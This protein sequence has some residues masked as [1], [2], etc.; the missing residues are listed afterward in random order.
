M[1]AIEILTGYRAGKIPPLEA[2]E[3]LRALGLQLSA[4][5]ILYEYLIELAT[6]N[7]N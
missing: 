7:L 3:K 4:N 2:S 1:T 6:K 5:E